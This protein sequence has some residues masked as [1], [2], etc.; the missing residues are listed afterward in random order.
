MIG[1]SSGMQSVGLDDGTFYNDIQEY[2]TYQD[3]GSSA[4]RSLAVSI[5]AV[6]VSPAAL[7]K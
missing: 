6:D 2:V 3:L 4:P 5:T 7:T 1:V